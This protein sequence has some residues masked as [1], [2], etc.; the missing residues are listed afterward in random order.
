M[1]KKPK[2]EVLDAEQALKE[3][4]MTRKEWNERIA[5]QVE[6]IEADKSLSRAEKD[7]KIASLLVMTITKNNRFLLDALLNG[8]GE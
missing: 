8:G 5:E 4:G 7:Q 2:I 1:A 3:S 6:H